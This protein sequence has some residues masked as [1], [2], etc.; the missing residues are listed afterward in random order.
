MK[1]LMISAAIVYF[2]SLAG[3]AFAANTAEQEAIAMAERGAAL[4]KAKG[5]TRSSTRVR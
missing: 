5:S 3:G 1:L 2:A 4:I